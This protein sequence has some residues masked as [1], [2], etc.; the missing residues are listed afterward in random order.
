MEANFCSVFIWRNPSIARSRRRNG[1]CKL[2][3]RLLPQRPTSCL[4]AMIAPLDH[5]TVGKGK[6][7]L[8]PTARKLPGMRITVVGECSHWLTVAVPDKAAAASPSSPKS[9]S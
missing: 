2:S 6:T 8:K 4:S 9:A 3:T 1:R 5:A 7:D